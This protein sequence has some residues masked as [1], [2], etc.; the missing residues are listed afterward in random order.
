MFYVTSTVLNTN[1]H[2]QK[3]TYLNRVTRNLQG[4]FALYETWC[5][6]DGHKIGE[7]RIV[8]VIGSL[9]SHRV[10]NG[11]EWWS[12]AGRS[13]RT[14]EISFL[15]RL[16]YLFSTN[17]LTFFLSFYSGL[18]YVVVLDL[19]RYNR[20]GDLAY[21]TCCVVRRF[22]K[23]ICSMRSWASQASE[24]G[25]VIVSVRWLIISNDRQ[26]CSW[27]IGPPFVTP[28][29]PGTAK[30]SQWTNVNFNRCPI[31]P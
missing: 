10:Q 9:L 16:S 17:L 18:C 26:G 27:S 19:D 15:V 1:F 11:E 3:I 28:L 6:D 5:D 7:L 14:G 8:L 12:R 21:G 13:R 24:W 2:I 29:L 22:D 25:P 31:M 20:C 23:M 30:V 4:S